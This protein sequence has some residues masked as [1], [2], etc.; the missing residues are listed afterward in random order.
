MLVTL[1]AQ[2]LARGMRDA[3]NRCWA[4]GSHQGRRRGEWAGGGRRGVTG[5][6]GGVYQG[7]LGPWMAVIPPP[8]EPSR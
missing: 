8:L 6:D 3:H 4:V 1:W 7:A 5:R 2:N